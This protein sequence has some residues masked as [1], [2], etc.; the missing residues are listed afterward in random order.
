MLVCLS[1]RPWTRQMS[2]AR[3]HPRSVLL[4]FEPHERQ[5][6][7]PRRNHASRGGRSAP[8]PPESGGAPHATPSGDLDR[9]STAARRARADGGASPGR[10]R[11]P[12][13]AALRQ[14]AG[15]GNDLPSALFESAPARLALAP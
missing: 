14:T 9:G 11:A 8:T 3:D 10:V 7:L 2:P 6:R 4:A 13:A 1:R 5:A 12:P 15:A